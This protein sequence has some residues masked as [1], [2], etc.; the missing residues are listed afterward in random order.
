[1]IL[2]IVFGYRSQTSKGDIDKTIDLEKIH[3]EAAKDAE[4]FL[5]MLRTSL[6][7]MGDPK[8]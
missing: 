7:K 5:V 6:L 8:H 4:D 1:M 2:I 3:R